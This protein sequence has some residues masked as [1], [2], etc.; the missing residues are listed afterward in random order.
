MVSH[1]IH[2]N[3]FIPCGPSSVI[4][5]PLDSA[6]FPCSEIRDVVVRIF[7]ASKQRKYISFT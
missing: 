3:R 4:A 6:S 5:L 7:D 1:S 2:V